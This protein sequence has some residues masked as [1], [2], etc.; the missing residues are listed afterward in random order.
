MPYALNRI[1][2]VKWT[3]HNYE[4]NIFKVLAMIY[5]WFHVETQIGRKL[6]KYVMSHWQS[7]HTLEG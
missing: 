1:Q 2:L 6:N 3:L 7:T 5:H 4:V